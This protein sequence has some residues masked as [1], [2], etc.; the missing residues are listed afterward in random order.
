M[1]RGSFGTNQS[2]HWRIGYS[3]AGSDPGVSG[4]DPIPVDQIGE[5][6]NAAGNGKGHRGFL[7]VRLRFTG[8]I[9]RQS[10]RNLAEFL[11]KNPAT[12][13]YELAIDVPIIP[14]TDAEIKSGSKGE[15]EVRVDW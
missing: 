4:S 15:W 10:L 5:G 9:G 6:V 14:R 7:R 3:D 1:G 13:D 8:Q 11:A 12:D 2:M